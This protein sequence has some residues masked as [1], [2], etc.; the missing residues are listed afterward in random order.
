MKSRAVCK[1]RSVLR[2]W[3]RVSIIFPSGGSRPPVALGAGVLCS[4]W[5]LSLLSPAG[6]PHTGFFFGL[7]YSSASLGFCP[8]A[9][10]SRKPAL[11]AL[12]A[13]ELPCHGTVSSAPPPLSQG[14]LT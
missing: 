13:L 11:L 8:D 5:N 14:Y 1:Q 10:S 12:E 3:I 2:K 9:P 6:C 7:T 4:L